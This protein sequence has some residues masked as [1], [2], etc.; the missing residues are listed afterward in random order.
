MNSADYAGYVNPRATFCL[1]YHVPVI[2]RTYNHKYSI[3][4]GRDATVHVIV[5]Q[6]GNKQHLFLLGYNTTVD[7]VP[8]NSQ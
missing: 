4:F 1:F 2:K 3:G 6:T 5:Q 7:T 8:Q